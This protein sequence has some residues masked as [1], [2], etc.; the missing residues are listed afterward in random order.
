VGITRVL[1]CVAIAAFAL[2]LLRAYQFYCRKPGSAAALVAP[3]K[4]G[5]WPYW[6][7]DH[8]YF[9]DEIY[10]IFIVAPLLLISRLLLGGLVELGIVQGTGA[11]LGAGTRGMGSIVRRMQSGNIRSYA[12]WLALGAAAVI[13][14]VVFT[15]H[16]W[17]RH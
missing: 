10:G 13:A 6:L 1:S 8:K 4:A 14:V 9:V 3:G 5:A 15:Y 7:V 12:G 2:G 17:L 16:P 11:G